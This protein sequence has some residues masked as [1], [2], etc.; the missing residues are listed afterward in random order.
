MFI[1]MACPMHVTNFP[2]TMRFCLWSQACR[3]LFQREA[4]LW[5]LLLE[6]GDPS[7]TAVPIH[8]NLFSEPTFLCFLGRCD[9][10]HFS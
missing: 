5:S 8:F 2:S 1:V 7:Q 3:F 4:V 10:C 9:P 6:D